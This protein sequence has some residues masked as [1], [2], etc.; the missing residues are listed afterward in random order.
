M[1]CVLVTA[2]VL[3]ASGVAALLIAAFL[4]AGDPSR[5]SDDD[6]ADEFERIERDMARER[7]PATNPNNGRKAT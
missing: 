6:L 5:T 4:G 7:H 2:A 3:V 1:T